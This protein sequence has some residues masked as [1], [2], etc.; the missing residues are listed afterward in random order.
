MELLKLVNVIID[1]IKKD[2]CKWDN[3]VSNTIGN[4]IYS[5]NTVI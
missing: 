1:P 2:P 3:F 5:I 4:T